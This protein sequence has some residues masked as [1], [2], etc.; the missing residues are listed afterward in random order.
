MAR[1]G[2]ADDGQVMQVEKSLRIAYFPF[3]NESNR[4]TDNFKKILSRFGDIAEA[5]PLKRIFGTLTRPRFDILILNWSDNNFVNPATG[6]VSV[7]GVIKEFV[8]IGIY[9]L[10][11]RKTIFVRHNIYPHNASEQS[12]DMV[13]RIIARY[14]KC[15]DL[16]WVHSGHLEEE[17]R[18]YVPHPLYE[19][20]EAGTTSVE[21]FALPER[22]FVVF[23]RLMEYKNIHRLLEIL[24][25]D[26]HLVVCGSCKDDAY[27]AKLQSLAGSNVT[28]MAQ[29]ISDELA[30]DLIT[31]SSGMVICHADDDMIVSGSII[32][33]I[34]LGVPVFAIETPFIRWF[35][36]TVNSNMVIAAGDFHDLVTYMREHQFSISESDVNIS[37]SHFS[38]QS[39]HTHVAVTFH[40]L[41]LI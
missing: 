4:Y 40:R 30:R 20:E 10:I 17:N 14:E 32:Y 9:N 1:I 2:H 25:S 35:H 15:F 27:K 21:E 22:Y 18:Y 38:D 26:M 19:I 3:E 13:S 33:S 6:R 34:S 39:V 41:G 24:P 23:G 36:D 29:F 8:R 37:Q 5:P 28:L 31:A 7:F 16:C 11:S 12:R